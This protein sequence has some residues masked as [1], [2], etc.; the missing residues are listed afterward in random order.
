[1]KEAIENPAID[2]SSALLRGHLGACRP[3]LILD[4]FLHS[5][6]VS[7][8]SDFELASSLDTED[9]KCFIFEARQKKLCQSPQLSSVQP[10]L[11]QEKSQRSPIISTSDDSLGTAGSKRTYEESM[12]SSSYFPVTLYITAVG[13]GVLAKDVSDK[14]RERLE[15][16]LSKI[17]KEQQTSIECGGGL[18]PLKLRGRIFKL[19]ICAQKGHL[20][21]LDFSVCCWL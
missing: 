19:C 15:S 10:C 9:R 3:A 14:A 13:D 7:L 8:P 1:M 21:H 18:V 20:T 2:L 12:Q 11:N 6:C 16:I 17:P 4:P 5:K